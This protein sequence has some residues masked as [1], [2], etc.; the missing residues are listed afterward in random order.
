MEQGEAF[1]KVFHLCAPAF[2]SYYLVPTD[3]WGLLPSPCHWLAPREILLL[4]VLGAVLASEAA[5]VRL[6]WL[7]FGMRQYERGRL[8]AHAWAGIGISI[9]FLFFP[10]AFV[11]AVV[12]GMAL[13]DPLMGL[14]RERMPKLYP[15]LPLLVYWLTV[16]A[17][18][19]VQSGAH[20]ALTANMAMVAACAAVLCESPKL[21]WLDDD[22][23]LLT[24]PLVALWVADFLFDG[25]VGMSLA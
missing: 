25:I 7:A 8:A 4:A 10:R 21:E 22:F 6:G 14:A 20:P 12:F 11:V 17:A 23:L 2:L 9:G 16:A 15:M 13:G 19:H 5:R 3:A 1:R 18:L 24:V